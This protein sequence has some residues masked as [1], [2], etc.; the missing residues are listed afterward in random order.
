MHCGLTPYCPRQTSRSRA[1]AISRTFLV[2]GRPPRSTLKPIERWSSDYTLVLD[3]FQLN[4]YPLRVTGSVKSYF[5]NLARGMRGRCFQ[6][7]RCEYVCVCIRF[8]E[9]ACV[10]AVCGFL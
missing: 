10:V 5:L 3:V 6:R 7:E 4:A 8:F 2:H 1:V 9:R